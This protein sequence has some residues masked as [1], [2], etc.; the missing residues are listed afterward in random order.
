MEE[1]YFEYEQRSRS[2]E[3]LLYE[4]MEDYFESILLQGHEEDCEMQKP[5]AKDF[6]RHVIAEMEGLGDDGFLDGA[7]K[8]ERQKELARLRQ[9]KFY[10]SHKTNYYIP[11]APSGESSSGFARRW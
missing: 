8:Y 10:N 1:S 3:F 2:K 6:S 5:I 7:E 9:Q 11:N 4:V